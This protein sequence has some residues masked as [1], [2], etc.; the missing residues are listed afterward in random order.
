MHLH[1]KLKKLQLEEE[2][3]A[4]IERDNRILLEKMSQIMRTN[5]KVDNYND[6]ECKSL[7]RQQ[8][9]RELLRITRENQQILKRITSSRP[10]YNHLQWERDWH[11]NVQL[12]DQI[13]AFPPDW[14]K[15]KNQGQAS[16]NNSG[17]QETKSGRESAPDKPVSRGREKSDLSHTERPDIR[18]REKSDLSQTAKTEVTESGKSSMHNKKSMPKDNSGTKAD[19]Q[20]DE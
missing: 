2:R 5:G 15:D 6:Y 1:L 16:S 19:M 7:N 4:T 8:R 10:R 12:M 3:L 13:S 9:L 17:W 18:H 11:A 20:N 14:W